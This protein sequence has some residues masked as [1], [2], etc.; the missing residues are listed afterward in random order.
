MIK[1]S[2]LSFCLIC[3]MV[4]ST[5]GCSFM[6]FGKSAKA[7]APVK[8]TETSKVVWGERKWETLRERQQRHHQLLRQV[9]DLV[10]VQGHHPCVAKKSLS[11]R[12]ARHHRRQIEPQRNNHLRRDGLFDR[13]VPCP[14]V[15]G[16]KLG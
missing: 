5:S 9:I 12:R 14:R 15:T 16:D 2:L 13:E 7:P 11:R 1:K 3:C 10:P 6:P 8:Q 4:V